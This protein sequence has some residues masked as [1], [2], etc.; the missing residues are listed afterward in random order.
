MGGQTIVGGGGL[1]RTVVAHQRQAF[2]RLL[3]LGQRGDEEED[4]TGDEQA[5]DEQHREREQRLVHG[6]T[7]SEPVTWHA[8]Y[9][10]TLLRGPLHVHLRT[11]Q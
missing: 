4:R 2:T 8:A 7:S 11:F 1:K 9:P 3:S 6:L 5:G 10:G